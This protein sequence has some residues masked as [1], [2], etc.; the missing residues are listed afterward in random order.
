MN[1]RASAILNYWFADVI[2][3]PALVPQRNPFWFG[4]GED[5]LTRDREIT[6]RFGDDVA[7]A[8]AGRLDD[9]SGEPRTALALILLLDQFPRNIFRGTARAFDGDQRA[10]SLTLNGLQSQQDRKLYP[11]ERV[12][13]LMPLQHAEDLQAQERGIL[14]FQRLVHEA[15]PEQRSFYDDVLTFAR[16][17]HDLVVQFGRFP[18][19]NAALGRANSAAETAYLSGEVERFGQ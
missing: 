9:W 15:A 5:V 8:L 13:Y 6:D 17:H 16:I 11:I 1:P 12:F 7:N 10:L 14:E 3:E 19:R 18:H 2:D 4:G